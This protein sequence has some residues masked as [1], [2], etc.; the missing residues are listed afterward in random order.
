MGYGGFDVFADGFG[1][2]DPPFCEKGALIIVEGKHGVFEQD[3]G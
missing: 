3:A 1:E 2:G